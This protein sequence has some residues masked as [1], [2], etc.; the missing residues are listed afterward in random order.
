[1]K[2]APLDMRAH[3]LAVIGAAIKD[4]KRALSASPSDILDVFLSLAMAIVNN[5]P[6][7]LFA[8]IPMLA[9]DEEQ[10]VNM[11]RAAFRNHRRNGAARGAL[12]KAISIRRAAGE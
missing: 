11:L 6:R 2:A 3:L 9:A 12:V 10:S 8:M 4:D 7:L 5:D 1:M